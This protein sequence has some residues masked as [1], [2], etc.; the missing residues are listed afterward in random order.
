MKLATTLA[1]ALFFNATGAGHFLQFFAI[2]GL[3]SYQNILLIV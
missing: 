3:T 1:I 2:S